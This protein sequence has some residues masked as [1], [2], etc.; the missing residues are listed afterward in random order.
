[1]ASGS[2]FQLKGKSRDSYLELVMAFPLAS[3]QSDEHLEP[4]ID[5]CAW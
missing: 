3:I 4:V 1:M 2:R 5:L